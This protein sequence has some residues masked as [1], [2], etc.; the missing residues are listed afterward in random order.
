LLQERPSDRLAWVLW[1][2]ETPESKIA[3]QPQ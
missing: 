2:G 3:A 1:A